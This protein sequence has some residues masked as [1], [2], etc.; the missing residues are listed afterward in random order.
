MVDNIKG[1]DSRSWG[2][3]ASKAFV[4][5]GDIFVP[6]RE[7]QIDTICSL[8]PAD[9]PEN[10]AVVELGAGDGALA[11]SVLRKFPNCRYLAL[12]GSESMRERLRTVL[13]PFGSRVEVRHFELDDEEWRETLP[14]PLR[15]VLASLVIHHLGGGGKKKLFAAM[16]SR[17]EPGGALVL[18]DLVEPNTS[19]VGGVFARQ[20]YEAVRAQ[21]IERTGDLKAYDFFR[22]DGWNYYDDDGPDPYDQP[23]RLFD[24]LTWLS[25]AGFKGVDCFWMRAGH[26]IFG[27]YV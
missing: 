20:W 5:R 3:D 26:A 16:A 14:R 17:L 18:A 22:D 4:D 7:E 23:S 24:Q 19:R 2:E 12:D 15:C 1:T 6:S 9:A 8:I 13:S 11:E 10:F 27:G 25:E 21:S